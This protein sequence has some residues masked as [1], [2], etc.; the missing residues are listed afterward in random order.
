MIQIQVEPG[1]WRAGDTCPCRV[2][3]RAARPTAARRVV[4]TLTA[5]EASPGSDS[6]SGRVLYSRTRELASPAHYQAVQIPFEMPI[7]TPDELERVGGRARPGTT[8]P[9]RYE[10]EVRLERP[11]RR[12]WTARTAI[13]IAEP[14]LQRRA[15]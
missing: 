6:T 13:D 8:E 11:W 2:A 9:V 1:P 10:L 15:S 14:E 5:F 4:A 7:P 12:D 3:I